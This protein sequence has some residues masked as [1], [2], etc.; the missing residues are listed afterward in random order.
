MAPIL[1]SA[2]GVSLNE[3]SAPLN[4]VLAALQHHCQAPPHDRDG[5]GEEEETDHIAALLQVLEQA[6]DNAVF[7]EEQVGAQKM[8]VCC[9]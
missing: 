2:T 8:T 9:F 6:C 7:Y 3:L 4:Q 1:T 5:D